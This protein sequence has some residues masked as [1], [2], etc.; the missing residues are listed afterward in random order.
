M[1]LR[2]LPLLLLVT[3]GLAD[4]AQAQSHTAQ[5]KLAQFHLPG[6]PSLPLPRLP[7]ALPP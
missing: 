1:K 7:V 5:V 3:L 6:L 4:R 2:F